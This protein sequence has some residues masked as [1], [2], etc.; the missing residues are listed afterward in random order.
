VSYSHRAFVDDEIVLDPLRSLTKP[1][2]MCLV[3]EDLYEI[4]VELLSDVLSNYSKFLDKE[5]FSLLNSLFNSPWAQERYERLIQGDYDF[6]SVQ[7]GMF[8]IAFGDATIQ[9]LTKNIETDP[10]CQ[11]FLSALGG[12]LGAEGY[13]VY[14]DKIFVPALEFW[15]TF[16][17]TMIDDVYS[18]EGERPAWFTAAQSHVIQAIERCLRKLQFPPS[19]IFNSWDSVDRTGF[20][21]ARR[22]FSDLI[23]QFYLTTGIRILQLFI[24]LAN[25]SISTK[26]WAEFEVAMFCLSWFADSVNEDDERDEYLHKVFAPPI[27]ALFADLGNEIPTRTKKSFLDMVHGYSDYFQNNPAQLSTVLN[28]VFTATGSLALAKT[29]SRY[30]LFIIQIDRLKNEI[31]VFLGH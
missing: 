9:D 13:A 23:Q 17:E 3:K 25:K 1:A 7:F 24:D 19:N 15:M 27:L 5:D 12:L 30:V 28:I 31:R 22:D 16:V 11:Q 10:Q 21:D 6:D 20:K 8:M 26:D 14:E 4:T 29:A 18:I 2:I